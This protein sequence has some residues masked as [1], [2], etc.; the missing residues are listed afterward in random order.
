[1]KHTASHAPFCQQTWKLALAIAARTHG[2]LKREGSPGCR[3]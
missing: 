3:P 2:D 1:M